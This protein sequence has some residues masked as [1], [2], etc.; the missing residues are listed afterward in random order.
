MTLEDFYF[1][2]QIVAALG[3]MASLVF[4]GLQMRAQARETRL[5]SMAEI[6]AEYRQGLGQMSSD[7]ELLKTLLKS[8]KVGLANLDSTA[9]LQA[10]LVSLS[11]LRVFE[12]AYIYRYEGKID[13]RT[14]TSMQGMMSQTFQYRACLDYFVLRKNDFTQIFV[15]FVEREYC[16]LLEEPRSR[17]TSPVPADEEAAQ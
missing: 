9:F 12:Q 3:I 8:N 7:R 1:I 5:A 11:F 16:D 17:D 14:W 13:D 6:M 10:S 4:V 15:D 2:S